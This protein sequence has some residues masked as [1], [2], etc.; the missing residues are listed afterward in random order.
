MKYGKDFWGSMEE[1]EL[2]RSFICPQNSKEF[3]RLIRLCKEGPYF[4][5]YTDHINLAINK[6]LYLYLEEIVC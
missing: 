2:A 3:I 5:I 4:R 1:C 6:R